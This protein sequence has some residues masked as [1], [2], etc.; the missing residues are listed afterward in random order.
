MVILDIWAGH[1]WKKSF[2]YHCSSNFQAIKKGGQTISGQVELIDILPTIFDVA[3]EDIGFPTD[4]QS[5]LPMIADDVGEKAYVRAILEANPANDQ[6][7]MVRSDAF[8]LI[9]HRKSSL[10]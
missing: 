2:M 4:G 8:R 5:L 7:Q 6:V 1:S 9:E 3:D 10:N